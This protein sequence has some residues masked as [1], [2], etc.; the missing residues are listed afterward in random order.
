MDAGFAVVAPD[1]F[2]VGELAL[3]KP[4]PVDK[5][6]A[7]YTYGYN[8]SLLAQRVHDILTF[9]AFGRSLLKAK[10]IDLVGWG[11]AGPWVV[12][13][14]ALAGDAVT[15]TAA[16]LNQFRFESIKTTDDP[17]MLPGAVKYGGLPAFL[18]LCAPGEVL[19][20]NHKGTSSG[21]LSKAAYDAAGAGDKLTRV[22][23]KL[24]PEKV[25]QWLAR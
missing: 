10:R 20:H 12:L 3:E 6:F 25:A 2:G 16:D 4:Y 17:M 14:K 7:G 24:P 1:V 23:E 15:R 11:E 21:K 18:A 22:D 8:R 9:V 5:N 13:A 19:A